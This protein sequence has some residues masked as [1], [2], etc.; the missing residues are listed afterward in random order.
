MNTLPIADLREFL[1]P[2]STPVC[3]IKSTIRKAVCLTSRQILA[4]S[5]LTPTSA[6]L[7]S[8]TGWETSEVPGILQERGTESKIQEK[9][10]G[11]GRGKSP[12]WD[13]AYYP[14]K[15]IKCNGRK[16]ADRT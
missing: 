3:C 6:V 10:R 4:Q 14:R 11:E 8:H 1:N 5:P 2:E 9:Q 7:L 13:P 15:E 16:A 12:T